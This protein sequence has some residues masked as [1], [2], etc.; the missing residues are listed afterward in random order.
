VG[1]IGDAIDVNIRA[2]AVNEGM[3][4]DLG[5][6]PA[7]FGYYYHHA[8][9]IMSAA[10]QVGDKANALR[11]AGEIEAGKSLSTIAPG[12][13][14]EA[15]R[16]MAMQA[17][18]QFM[19][20]T[21][22]LAIKAPPSKLHLLTVAWRSARIEAY[23][24]QGSLAGA[25]KEVLLL[26]KARAASKDTGDTA[27]IAER[28]EHLALGR[29]KMA[30]GHAAEAEAHFLAAAETDKRLSYN[31]P[32]LADRPAQI[33]LGKLK[34]TAGDGKGALAAFDAALKVRPGNAYA[35]WGKAQAQTKLGDTAGSQAT[36]AEFNRVWRGGKSPV[37][38]ASL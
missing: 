3:A 21:E 30:A 33:A 23:L 18:A 38:I 8:T 20:P 2:I 10:Q 37:V 19:T 24:A 9:F 6:Q 27:R 29:I 13:W 12:S 25:R 1:R 34:L 22:V 17:R 15:K 14:D 28:H 4:R 31:E 11:L 32:P 35:L 5:K 7:Y 36:M 26:K 16:L